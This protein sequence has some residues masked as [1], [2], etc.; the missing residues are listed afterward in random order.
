MKNIIDTENEANV[1]CGE[2]NSSIER[3][4]NK[5]IGFFSFEGRA[6]RLEYFKVN[7]ML[8][9]LII[10]NVT[11]LFPSTIV[12]YAIGFAIVSCLIL[13]AFAPITVRRLHDSNLNGGYYFL[14]LISPFV[15][16]FLGNVSFGMSIFLDLVIGSIGLWYCYLLF[17]QGTTGANDHGM[18]NQPKKYGDRTIVG[19]WIGLFIM[20]IFSGILQTII[21]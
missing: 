15:T 19:I 6:N 12:E 7:I 17:R 20:I 21:K 14:S 8:W 4:G 2:D 5:P 18:P 16:L 13:L 9:L 11:Y 3:N 10:F 1:I